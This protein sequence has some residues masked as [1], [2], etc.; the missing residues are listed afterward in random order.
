MKQTTIPVLT[1]AVGVI[2]ALLL[3]G[4]G[5]TAPQGEQ[6]LPLLMLLFASELGFLVTLGGAIYG[7]KL[8]QQQQREKRF[9]LF[10]ALAGFVLAAALLVLG[11]TLWF[12]T[13][14]G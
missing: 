3:I 5:A 8:W 2:I 13:T 9:L 4:A 11:L 7:I 6:K 1:T 10:G 14:A 12:T